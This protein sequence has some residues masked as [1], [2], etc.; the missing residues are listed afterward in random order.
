MPKYKESSL[1]TIGMLLLLLLVGY[2]IYTYYISR[3]DTDDWH[4]EAKDFLSYIEVVD[5]I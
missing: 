4:S 2:C 1:G 3:K 5:T